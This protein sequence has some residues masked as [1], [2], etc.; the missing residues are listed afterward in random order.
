M[1]AIFSIIAIIAAF[2]IS[3]WQHST[4]RVLGEARQRENDIRRLKAVKAVLAQICILSQVLHKAIEI[5]DAEELYNFD[6]QFLVDYK[7][8]LQSLPL[9]EVPS[10]ELVLYVNTIPR[11]ID[12]VTM[13]LST[14]RQQENDPVSRYERLLANDLEHRVE[15]LQNIAFKANNYCFDEVESLGGW[16]SEEKVASG[17][18]GH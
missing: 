17:H 16:T 7:A 3:N 4:E 15:N 11:A 13:R 12:E 18:P 2:A 9:F 14:A 6:P 8:V 1:Q 5:N 10:A